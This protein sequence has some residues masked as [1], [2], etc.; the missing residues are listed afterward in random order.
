MLH[1]INAH[2]TDAVW[3]TLQYMY[4]CEYTHVYV[5]VCLSL[6]IIHVCMCLQDITINP[7][8]EKEINEL[9][10]VHANIQIT[11]GGLG[12]Y[13]KPKPRPEPIDQLHKHLN[14]HNIKLMDVFRKFDA[15]DSG[16]VSEA[17]FR[18]AIK[19]AVYDCS[20]M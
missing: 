15:E 14:E 4:V 20:T 7:E 12:G 13:V 5:C 8:V 19:V 6:S 10:E 3:Y 2:H 17:N 11:H 18:E 1:F 9:K 16:F